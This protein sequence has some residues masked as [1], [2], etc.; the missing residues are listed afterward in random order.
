VTGNLFT[1]GVFGF[2]NNI[3]SL[4]IIFKGSSAPN[5]QKVIKPK[6]C[7]IYCIRTWRIK[8]ALRSTVDLAAHRSTT[9]SGFQT[10]S[11]VLFLTVGGGGGG[12]GGVRN[13][14]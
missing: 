11:T 6:F 10:P 14:D 2:A 5:P 4:Q 13:G 7:L 3:S 1:L 8:N 9:D 12:G